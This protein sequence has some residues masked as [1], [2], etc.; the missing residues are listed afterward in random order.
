MDK[1]RKRKSMEEMY[2]YWLHNVKGIGRVTFRK[3]LNCMTPKELYE[4]SLMGTDNLLTEKQRE[5]IKR[6]RESWDL[7]KEWSVLENRN[8]TLR[9]MKTPEYPE[10]LSRISDPPPV[11]YQKGNSNIL[12]KPSVAVI[13]ARACSAYGSLMAKELGKQLAQTG[14]V[15]ISGMA[16]GIDSICQWS[17]LVHG[18]ES[19]G[20]LGSGVEICYPPEER[21]LY[22]RLQNKGCLVSENLPFTQ[23]SAGLFPLRN[24]IISGLADA[25]VVVE[26][27]E[28]SGTLITVDMALE[29]GKEVYA[30]PG[31]STDSVSRGCNQ[32][33]KQGAGMILSPG[34]F[35]E[36]ICPLLKIKYQEVKT[37]VLAPR[38]LTE[39]KILRIIGTGAKTMEDIY[40]EM[41]NEEGMSLGKVMEIVLELQIRQMIVGENGYYFY[42]KIPVATREREW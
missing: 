30:V 37:E 39:E 1:N 35:V 15:V 6:S 38:T 34:E 4:S 40:Q 19:V 13:G 9:C 20:V 14:I 17:S 2:Y 32:L 12:E 22:E 41:K 24:R 26:A 5:S 36:E 29:Q 18:G 28:K 33:L 23:P 31:R 10:K 27:R 42:N 3:I 16:R 11:I 7:Q 25:V 21:E 8:I